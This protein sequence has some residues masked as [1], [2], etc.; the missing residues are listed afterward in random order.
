MSA[1]LDLLLEG[2]LDGGGDR[3]RPTQRR[4]PHDLVALQSGHLMDFYRASARDLRDRIARALPQWSPS[5]PGLR[6]VLGMYAFGLEETGDYA[7]AEED[8][9]SGHRRWSRSTAGPTMPSRMSWRCRAA[10]QD[11]IGW[12]IA[13][14]PYWSGDDNFFKVH[15]WWHRALCH[16]DLG[17]GDEVLR[18]LRRS[19]S[20]GA[21]APSRSI[22]S[23]PRR[24]CGGCT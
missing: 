10:P 14:E 9:P 18:A 8:G 17:Q 13:R 12:M 16:L 22:S 23:M 20:R 1:A 3:A 2:Q 21:A 6:I 11:G 7:R 15:N 24:C 5:M 19:D 4:Y